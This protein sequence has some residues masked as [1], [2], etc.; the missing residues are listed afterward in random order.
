MLEQRIAD[1]EDTINDLKG[2]IIDLTEAI[3]GSTPSDASKT[4][5]KKV[6]TENAKVE[7]KQPEA[8]KAEPKKVAGVED[9]RAALI[10]LSKAKGKDAAKNVLAD[11]NASKVGDLK[12]SEYTKV[13]EVATKYQEAA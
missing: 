4:K 8:P 6:S 1:L 10:N 5:A 2:V 9:V 11:F 12:E 13:V 7:E 3:K